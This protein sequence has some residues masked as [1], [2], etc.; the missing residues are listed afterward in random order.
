MVK[1]TFFIETKKEIKFMIERMEWNA[2]L[3]ATHSIMMER[4]TQRNEK[5][6]VNLFNEKGTNLSILKMEL[7][8]VF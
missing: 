6:F 1:V 3:I 8:F 5:Q 2:K 7:R 4:I